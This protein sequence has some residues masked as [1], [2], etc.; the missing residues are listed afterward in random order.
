MVKFNAGHQCLFCQQIFDSAADKDDHILEHFAQETCAECDENLIRIGGYLYVRHN[1]TTCIKKVSISEEIVKSSTIIKSVAATTVSDP[2]EYDKRST[3]TNLITSDECETRTPEIKT[4]PVDQHGKVDVLMD[5]GSSTHGSTIQPSASVDRLILSRFPNINL[6]S[7]V[8]LEDIF[9]SSSKLVSNA[10]KSIPMDTG[11][12]ITPQ[13]EGDSADR[14]EKV[15]MSMDAG[16][17]E[18]TI[19]T[20]GCAIKL[21][22]SVDC[23][24]I[25][26]KSLSVNIN[27]VV[28][29]EDILKKTDVMHPPQ[30][31]RSKLDEDL[32]LE[33]KQEVV[34]HENHEQIDEQRKIQ[35]ET[36]T[37]D[38]HQSNVG[39]EQLNTVSHICEACGKSFETDAQL[40]IHAY[41]H[42]G[43]RPNKL[44]EKYIR[45]RRKRYHH[46]RMHPGL[47]LHYC[48]IDGCNSRYGNVQLL[49]LHKAKVHGTDTFKFKCKIC[50]GVFDTEDNLND[51]MQAKHPNYATIGEMS[52]S[53]KQQN[54]P[55]SSCNES[56]QSEPDHVSTRDIDEMNLKGTYEGCE[57]RCENH[58]G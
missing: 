27:P 56:L 19:S 37:H 40:R 50:Y 5:T 28:V 2:L 29:L 58:Q 11:A 54:H 39:T 44:R 8:V 46:S 57:Q 4:E 41:I 18:S 36:Q 3:A 38:L 30:P 42:T 13:I 16:S 9:L 51:H 32:E 33:I 26:R 21:S 6:N 52:D 55:S 48:S 31:K 22:T 43:S 20:H 1:E 24:A 47:Q 34:M 10:A 35:P 17:L 45:V 23:L 25:Q 14:H 7:V 53:P 12:T 49:R 15:D